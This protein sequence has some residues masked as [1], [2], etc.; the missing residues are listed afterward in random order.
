M[1]GKPLTYLCIYQPYFVHT[2]PTLQDPSK[3]LDLSEVWLTKSTVTSFENYGRH[4]CLM[5]AVGN[6]H[7]VA[8][9][10]LHHSKYKLQ[11]FIQ[12]MRLLQVT[13]LYNFCLN[14][15][16]T[17]QATIQIFDEILEEVMVKKTFWYFNSCFPG[18]TNSLNDGSNDWF[19]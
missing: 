16:S 6:W 3:S 15:A 7:R 18:K 1:R 2:G 9:I 14:T 13:F 12:I 4:G 17:L 8:C 5:Q 11:S 19:L 10:I